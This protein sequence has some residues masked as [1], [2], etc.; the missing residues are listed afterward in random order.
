MLPKQ[1][2]IFNTLFSI[3][4]VTLKYANVYTVDKFE[5][6]IF[7]QRLAV[8]NEMYIPVGEIKPFCVSGMKLLKE[9]KE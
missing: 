3:N 7:L 1:R 2:Y 4:D 9:K 8:N 6:V 5:K